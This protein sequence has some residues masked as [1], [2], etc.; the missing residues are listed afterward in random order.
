MAPQCCRDRRGLQHEKHTGFAVELEHPKT[1]GFELA[2]IR[3]LSRNSKRSYVGFA[4]TQ[5]CCVHA[6]EL[7]RGTIGTH[8][9][10]RMF[11]DR[12]HERAARAGSREFAVRSILRS[13]KS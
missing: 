3:E 8:G 6:G 9:A 13:C 10:R 7:Q 4:A 2:R 5:S 1:S 12:K 11:D